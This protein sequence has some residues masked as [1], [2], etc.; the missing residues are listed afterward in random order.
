MVR[1][2]NHSR[3]FSCFLFYFCFPFLPHYLFTSP[4]K[5]AYLTFGTSFTFRHPV[6]RIKRCSLRGPNH[7]LVTGIGF[8]LNFKLYLIEQTKSLRSEFPGRLFY[9]FF[10]FLHIN[11]FVPQG[12]LARTETG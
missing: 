8:L 12:F 11:S 6:T 1:T 7:G 4:E 9:F 3:F 10:F 5:I 2:T